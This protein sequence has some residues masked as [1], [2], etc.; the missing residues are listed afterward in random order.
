M[1]CFPV[2]DELDA[3]EAAEPADLPDRWVPV[4]QLAEPLPEIRPYIGGVLDDTLLAEGLDR[5]H[6]G[7][8]RERMARIRKPAREELVANP[9][10][11]LRADDHRSEGDVARVDA[12]GDGDDVG[13]D[14]PVLTGEPATGPP[15]AGHDLVENEQDAVPVADLAD[16]LQVAVR[17]RDDPVRPGDRLEEHGGN[18]VR[19]FVLEDLL[20][21]R[22]ARADGA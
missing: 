17:R 19:T 7:R 5:G 11:Q 10:T 4:A 22:C 1:A 20:Q 14:V 3:P 9:L 2:L 21:M 15:E 13:D 6:R 16:R 8:A 12:L 18:G